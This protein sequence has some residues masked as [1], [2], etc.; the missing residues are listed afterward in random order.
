MSSELISVIV[1]VYNVENYIAKCINSLLEQTYSNFEVIVVDDGSTDKSISIV[2]SMTDKDSRFKIVTKSNGGLSSARNF[3]VNESKGDYIAFLDSDDYFSSSFLSKMLESKLKYNADITVCQFDL[4]T[5]EGIILEVRGNYKLNYLTGYQAF[6]DNLQGISITSGAPNKLYSRG[7]VEKY[8]FPEGLLYED[9][10]TM[11]KMFL[12][13]KVVSF[14]NEPLFH[15]LQRPGSIMNSF[16]NK[17]LDDRF[18]VFDS[19]LEELS[20][21][22][23]IQKLGSEI[24]ICFLLNVY[25]GGAFQISRYSKDPVRLINTLKTKSSSYFDSISWKSYYKLLLIN[26][27]KFF[28]LLILMSSS[29][30]FTRLVRHKYD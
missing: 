27:K 3:G 11:Y 18:I 17:K 6:L 23:L 28:A 8:P 4:V 9:R 22:K 12:D 30:L 5:E 14:V 29:K 26:H 2:K 10:A 20:K 16:D 25:L 7:I 21:R 13:S 1:P 15:Y 24:G 19:I